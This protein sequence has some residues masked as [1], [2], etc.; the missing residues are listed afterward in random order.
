M[1][2]EVIPWIM[3]AVSSGLIAMAASSIML[4]IIG[5]SFGL[6]MMW[7]IRRINK[8]EPLAF[9]IGGRYIEHQKFYLNVAKHPSKPYVINNKDI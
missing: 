9:K 5:V 3:A 7:I 1:G 2:C 4:K 8:R 6:V